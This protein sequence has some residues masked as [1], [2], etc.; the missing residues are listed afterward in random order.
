MTK[1]DDNCSTKNNAG[2]CAFAEFVKPYL[3]G[4]ILDIGCGVLEMPFYLSGYP[5]KMIYGVDPIRGKVKR[6]LNF[7][8]SYA[9]FLPFENNF[10]DTVIMATSL[11]HTFLPEKA[12]AEVCRVL[13]P[14][15]KFIIWEGVHNIFHGSYENYNPFSSQIVALDNCHLFRFTSLSLARLIFPYFSITAYDEGKD[16]SIMLVCT[17]KQG[18]YNL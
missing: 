13:A 7:T 8:Q 6:N 17:L 5:A 15:G 4:K 2:A 3:A 9:E 18:K 10:F 16:S 14:K 1:T 11:D 12:I